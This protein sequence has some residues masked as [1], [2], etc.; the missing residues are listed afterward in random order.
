MTDYLSA[1]AEAR[2]GGIQLAGG[3]HKGQDTRRPE[4]PGRGRPQSVDTG[5]S[6][7]HAAMCTDSLL[8]PFEDHTGA[9]GSGCHGDSGPWH[10]VW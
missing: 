8:I 9:D 6:G 5:L 1:V 10:P 3:E 4:L 7:F 2:A